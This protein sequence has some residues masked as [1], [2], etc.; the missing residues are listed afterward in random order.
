MKNKNL[1]DSMAKKLPGAI[2]NFDSSIYIDD[3]TILN[4]AKKLFNF[5]EKK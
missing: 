2:I 1:L 5:E 3:Q 4:L